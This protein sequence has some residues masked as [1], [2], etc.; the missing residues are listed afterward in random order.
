MLVNA[1]AAIQSTCGALVAAGAANQTGP[2]AGQQQDLYFRCNE[3][4]TTYGLGVPNPTANSYGFD[5]DV[6][7]YNAVRQFS[8]EEASTQRRLDTEGHN[9]QFAGIGARMD[10]IRRGARGASSG[11]AMNFDNSTPAGAIPLFGGA[12]GDEGDADTGWGWFGTVNTGYADRDRTPNE[13]AY[14]SNYYG[15]TL[16][17]DYALESGVVLGV[18]AGYQDY[19]VD[20]D[21]STPTSTNPASPTAGGGVDGNSY[22][23]SGYA[24]F[25]AEDWFA[26]AIVS[27]G[28]ADYDIDRRAFFLPGPNAQ[29][30]PSAQGFVIDRSYKA[31]TE[32]NQ[33]GAEL[34]F[35]GAILNEGPWSLDAYVKVDYLAVQIDGYTEKETDRSPTPT[36]TPGLALK[37]D[38]QDVNTTESG[39]GFT[40]RR[41]FNTGFGVV[42]PYLG[43]EWR[44]QWNAGSGVVRYSYAF[45]L[46]ALP[47]GNLNF[48]STTDHS[49]KTY[50]TGTAGVSTQ[51]AHNLTAFIQ[52]EGLIGLSN[53]TGGMGT[54]GLRGTF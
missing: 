48:A 54:I 45:A 3:M 35:G 50:G 6:N 4:V 9:L 10:A 7:R 25:N 33:A 11:I 42:V 1:G 38:N 27:Y 53:T 26:S 28:S 21:S 23:A 24:L 29:G 19:S 51:F 49:D 52:Y 36:P 34:T 40:L 17:V 20:V 32:S 5:N 39:M 30:R 13:D 37:F 8:G 46:P 2:N 12:A 43:A 16:G 18:A 15:G 47:N 31:D 44:Y 41:S 14:D 22:S